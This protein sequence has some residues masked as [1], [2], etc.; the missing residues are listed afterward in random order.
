MSFWLVLMGITLTLIGFSVWYDDRA[1]ARQIELEQLEQ[2]DSSELYGVDEAHDFVE[3][4]GSM[5][6]GIALA[7]M[8][9]YAVRGI[10][11]AVGGV[12]LVILGTT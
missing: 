12:W 7:L 11:T 8:L 9:F 4:W 6:E 1:I 10:I 5:G 2:E 3:R